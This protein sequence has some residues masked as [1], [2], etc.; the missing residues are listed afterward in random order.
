MAP[1]RS[2]KLIPPLALSAF[3]LVI[4]FNITLS[5]HVGSN[6]S[7]QSVYE[8][9][10]SNVL[11][12]IA[13]GRL[14]VRVAASTASKYL[15]ALIGSAISSNI[16]VSVDSTG[17]PLESFLR[18]LPAD[19]V[20]IYLSTGD[21]LLNAN[22]EQIIVEFKKEVQLQGSVPQLL[23]PITRRGNN[24]EANGKFVAPF[25]WIATVKDARQ[26]A[27]DFAKSGEVDFR[28][29]VR[30]EAHAFDYS[31]RLFLD[32]P[33]SEDS[34]CGWPHNLQN[35]IA[36]CPSQ[37]SPSVLHFGNTQHANKIFFQTRWWNTLNQTVIDSLKK[38]SI[39]ID[40]SISSLLEFARRGS[41]LLVKQKKGSSRNISTS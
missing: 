9:E 14:H 38:T 33:S 39:D 36:V 28:E 29:R 30:A 10:V 35:P 6:V 26:L 23:W 24:Y 32:I 22:A 3:L 21:V 11:P 13:T 5:P 27:D 25:G 4:L 1:F 15:C 34:I 19:D 17:S 37:V 20:V 41:L 2:N 12:L 40:G 8:G 16:T 18:H 31:S 7:I